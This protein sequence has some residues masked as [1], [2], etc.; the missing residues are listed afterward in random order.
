M[1]QHPGRRKV[2]EP[3]LSPEGFTDLE[4]R[5]INPAMNNTF[6]NFSKTFDFAY[7]SR[8]QNQRF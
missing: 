8:T 4:I 5:T 7:A 1:Y 3:E 2:G 6:A